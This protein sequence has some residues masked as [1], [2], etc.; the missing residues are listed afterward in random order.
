MHQTGHATTKATKATRQTK[1]RSHPGR[2][3]DPKEDPT[4]KPPK[5][6]NNQDLDDREYIKKVLY[7]NY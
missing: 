3:K 5:E 4:N 7:L 6:K 2:K 1:H